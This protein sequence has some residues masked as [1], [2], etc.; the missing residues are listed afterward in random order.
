M[1][2][3]VPVPVPC[4]LP[5]RHRHNCLPTYQTNGAQD[6]RTPRNEPLHSSSFLAIF[7]TYLL[8]Y[9][10]PSDT[11]ASIIY[12]NKLPLLFP[13]YKNI[14]FQRAALYIDNQFTS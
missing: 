3:P 2:V 12:N 9:L 10:H 7:H 11:D 14:Q 1:P 13:E 6:K 5:S 4:R 8:T